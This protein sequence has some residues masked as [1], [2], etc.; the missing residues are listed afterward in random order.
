[1]LRVQRCKCKYTSQLPL[2]R[3]VLWFANR[4]EMRFWRKRRGCSLWVVQMLSYWTHQLVVANLQ[5]R[6]PRNSCYGKTREKYR[7]FFRLKMLCFFFSTHLLFSE[8]CTFP[9][10][11]LLPLTL[12]P[13]IWR[14]SEEHPQRSYQHPFRQWLHLG[15]GLTSCQVWRDWDQKHSWACTICTPP[16]PPASH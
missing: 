2:V 4:Q 1:M 9:F 11:P 14:L 12:A 10:I 8:L 13:L 15:L 16:P 3:T 5:T 6:Y 7:A